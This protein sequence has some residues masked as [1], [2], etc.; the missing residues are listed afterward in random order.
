M[1]ASLFSTS[2]NVHSKTITEDTSLY[3]AFYAF[4]AYFGGYLTILTILL[5][6]VG[7]IISLI[8]FIRQRKKDSA[9][10]IY[11]GCLAVTDLGNLISGIIFWAHQSLYYMSFGAYNIPYAYTDLGCKIL[12]YAWYNFMFLSGWIIIAFSVERMIAVVF[13]LNVSTVVTSRRRKLVLVGLLFASLAIWGDVG[14]LFEVY[15]PYPPGHQERYNC[16]FNPVALPEWHLLF[17]LI[18]LFSL[19]QFLPIV[20]L[21]ILNTIIIIGIR[22]NNGVIEIKDPKRAKREMRCTLN[23]ISVSTA[24]TVLMTPYLITWALY[25]AEDLTGW[26]GRSLAYVDFLSEVAVYTISIGSINYALNFVIYTI[27]LD[28]YRAELLQ[29]LNCNKK[30]LMRTDI[31]FTLNKIE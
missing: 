7:N 3:D 11:L 2:N 14:Q 31:S 28:F 23:L 27:S 6:V 24:Y 17:F 9:S 19:T 21:T 1:V 10:A 4:V 8:I 30:K 15:G 20:I 13:P 26:K 29:V 5:G 18:R 12:C 22:R 25:M 16:F